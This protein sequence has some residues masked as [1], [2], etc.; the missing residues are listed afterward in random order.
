[1]MPNPWDSQPPPDDLIDEVYST[2]FEDLLKKLQITI[3]EAEHQPDEIISALGC[4]LTLQFF[5]TDDPNQAFR[6]FV[7][8]LAE[9]F[10]TAMD[11]E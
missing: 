1:M 4:L 9:N 11:V 3:A 10:D 2:R 8:R 6:R 7:Q 5:E